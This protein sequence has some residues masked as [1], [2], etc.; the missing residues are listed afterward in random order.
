MSIVLLWSSTKLIVQD[1][2]T[3]M[4][5][6]DT[7]RQVSY[8]IVHFNGRSSSLRKQWV[9][10]YT[11]HRL[12]WSH[13]QTMVIR[14]YKCK[15]QNYR[16]EIFNFLC[17]SCHDLQIVTIDSN[18]RKICSKQR[19][20]RTKVK[21][22]CISP[23]WIFTFQFHFLANTSPLHSLPAVTTKPAPTYQYRQC[24]HSNLNCKF[25]IMQN[26]KMPV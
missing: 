2:T 24:H 15:W 1:H 23:P 8:N 4:Q 17:S 10:V 11:Q 6:Y 20:S 3:L 18:N 21:L 12:N 22:L 19:W 26:A 13:F 25:V 16:L 14:E 5:Q 7:N 9:V